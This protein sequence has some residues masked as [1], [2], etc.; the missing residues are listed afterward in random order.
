MDTKLV[1]VLALFEMAALILVARLWL[2]RRRMRIVPRVFWSLVLLVPVFGLM[3]YALIHN[4]PDAHPEY[5]EES[6]SADDVGGG[7]GGSD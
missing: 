7:P 4:D 1:I 2:C 6:G 3:L 5:M